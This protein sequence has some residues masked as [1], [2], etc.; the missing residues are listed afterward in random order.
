MTVKLHNASAGPRTA[1]VV[2]TV[3]DAGGETVARVTRDSS[4]DAGAGADVVASVT[5]DRAHLWNGRLDPYL[6]RVTAA[7]YDGGRLVDRVV[8][9]LG[10]RFFEVDPERGVILNGKPYPLHGVNRHQEVGPRGWAARPADVDADYRFITEMGCTAVRLP[11]YQHDPYEYGL[12]DRLG[13]I[14]WAELAQVDV[15]G[16]S[17]QYAENAKQQLREL[18]KQNYNHPSIFFWSLWNEVRFKKENQ[19]HDMELTRALNDLA[20]Q[21][22][23]SRP[24]VTAS[25]RKPDD[26]MNWLPDVS[27][28]NKYWGWYYDTPQ[29]W[30][31]KL[32]EFR[33]AAPKDQPIGVSEYGAGASVRDHEANPTTRPRPAAVPFHP[34]EWQNVVH[35]AAYGAMKDRRWVW[36]TFL[37]CMFDFSSDGRH[38]GD[39]LGRNDKGLVTFDRKTRK[40]AFYYYKA[41]WSDEPFVY[42]TSRRFTPRPTGPAEVKVYSNCDSVELF[43]GGKALGSRTGTN[44]VFVWPGVELAAGKNDVRAVGRRGGKTVDDRC[45]WTASPDASPR[46]MTP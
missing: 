46:L 41:N 8:Q 19:A 17:P 23:S 10:L 44:G 14:L 27:S 9:P 11:H 45:T 21:L 28:F 34:E 7:V 29:D 35:E 6:Y 12:C 24:T 37:W 13:L 39:H 1:R 33:A 16:K 20:H 43:L 5:L 22:D 30:G 31:R 26:P 40:D 25:E 18:I 36:G 3:T 2:Y 4:L 42:I 32:D 15:M 38:E